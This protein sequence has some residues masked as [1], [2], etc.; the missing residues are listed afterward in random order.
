MDR[1]STSVALPREASVATLPDEEAD[2]VA[3][4]ASCRPGNW[5]PGSR[6]TSSD[7]PHHPP[8]HQRADAGRV[9]AGQFGYGGAVG[10]RV[11]RSVRRAHREGVDSD[12]GRRAVVQYLP[13][14]SSRKI[15]RDEESGRTHISVHSTSAAD[16]PWGRRASDQNLIYDIDDNRPEAAEL[17]SD[18]SITLSL[19]NGSRVL[20]YRG[21]MDF[22]GD[23]DNV[24]YRYRRTLLENG[25]Q[26]RE[27][28]W[29]KTVPRDHH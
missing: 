17:H 4:Q 2:H 7:P 3:A 25:I 21:W 29:E 11:E 13:G 22:E 15:D 23:R 1:F 27:K 12:A 24:Y 9:P 26:I 28:S 8:P 14:S 16:Y 18:N 19:D 10:S 6:D 20:V 5:L